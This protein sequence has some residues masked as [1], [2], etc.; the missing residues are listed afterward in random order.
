MT[1]VCGKQDVVIVFV[2]DVTNDEVVVT[3]SVT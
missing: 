3:T 1:D 2:V